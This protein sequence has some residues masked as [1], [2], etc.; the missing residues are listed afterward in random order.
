[1]ICGDLKGFFHTFADGNAGHNYNKLAPTVTLIQL[2]HRFDVNIGLA[3]TGLHLDI[4]RAATQRCH[5]LSRLVDIALVL[6][7]LDIVQ[8]LL[9][10]QLQ[11]FILKTGIIQSILKFDLRAILVRLR[12][13]DLLRCAGQITNITQIGYACIVRLPLKDPCHGIHG[14][15]LVLLNLK[16]KL[17][18]CNLPPTPTVNHF[19]TVENNK[20][21]QFSSNHNTFLT[22]S[23]L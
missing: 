13:T 7:V 5:Q 12:H 22:V 3:G 21:I 17:H 15:R 4:Q 10:G 19:L 18:C 14:I 23:G 11:G 1:M 20:S 6:N 8:N 9:I 16:T 2:E